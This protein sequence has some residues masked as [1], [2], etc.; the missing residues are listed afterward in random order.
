MILLILVLAIVG[1]M[2]VFMIFVIFMVFMPLRISSPRN[3]IITLMNGIQSRYW[4]ESLRD[5]ILIKSQ[6]PIYRDFPI[7]CNTVGGPSISISNKNPP[8]RVIVELLSQLLWDM[9]PAF[10]S[11]DS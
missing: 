7:N 1:V 3:L 11:K 2:K 10:G 6:I 8:F 5:E 4:H 9:D